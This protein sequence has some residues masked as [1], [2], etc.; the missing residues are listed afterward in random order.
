MREIQ[1]IAR[2]IAPG[3]PLF[4]V[5]T[6]TESLDTLSGFLLF[7]IGAGIAAATGMLGLILTLIGV[8]GV[9]SYSVRQ[10]TREIAIRRS[11]RN[12]CRF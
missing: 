9:I 8:Y 12:V 11:G 10:H 4:N 7:Q 1:D 5:P 2:D 6:L 3:L